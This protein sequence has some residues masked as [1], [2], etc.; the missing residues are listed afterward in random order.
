MPALTTAA[1]KLIEHDGDALD[2]MQIATFLQ[3]HLGL[4]MTSYLA[5]LGPKASDGR[6][7]S[8]CE[9]DLDAPADRRL[10]SGYKAVRMIVEAYDATTA[11]AW[12]FGTNPRLEDQAPIE[13]LR[14]AADQLDMDRAVRTA[15][16]FSA[17]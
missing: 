6:D 1:L 15:Q 7:A 9:T 5:G 10:R 16:G 4:R 2:V 13:V 14:R 8:F 12:L 11:R 3:D 17:A